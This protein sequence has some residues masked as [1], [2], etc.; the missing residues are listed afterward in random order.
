ML[1]SIMLNAFSDLLCS[2]L[3]WHNR[4]VPNANLYV[5]NRVSTIL[6]LEHYF[7]HNKYRVKSYIH[8]IQFNIY[9]NYLKIMYRVKSL[10]DSIPG[11]GVIFKVFWRAYPRPPPMHAQMHLCFTHYEN[12]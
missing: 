2:K 3:C 10:P 11:G 1:Y 4:L 8:I 5:Y 6:V 12:T 7:E 9:T